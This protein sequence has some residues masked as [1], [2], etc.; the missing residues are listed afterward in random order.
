ML[1]GVYWGHQPDTGSI[2]MLETL[3]LE[4]A[5][6]FVFLIIV[7]IDGLF[8]VVISHFGETSLSY[9]SFFALRSIRR[10]PFPVPFFLI[11][12]INNLLFYQK[13]SGLCCFPFSPMSRVVTL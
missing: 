3:G 7:D 13:H 12:Q 9:I 11:L 5:A 4:S 10:A 1:V 8:L 6:Y 2:L